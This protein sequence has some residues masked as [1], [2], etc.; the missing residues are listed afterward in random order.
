MEK[1]GDPASI[2][3]IKQC[4]EKLYG[5]ELTNK[6]VCI[7][8]IVFSILMPQIQVDILAQN[9][10]RYERIHGKTPFIVVQPGTSI[11]RSSR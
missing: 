6:M 3:D 1:L 8:I 2:E 11:H 10:L 9:R 7:C 4:Y 5:K